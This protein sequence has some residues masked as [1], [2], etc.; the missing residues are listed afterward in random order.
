MDGYTIIVSHSP[1]LMPLIPPVAQS[2]LLRLLT[3][4]LNLALLG[5]TARML[6]AGVRG[7]ISLLIATLG[8]AL[9]IAGMGGGSQLVYLLPQHP[10]AGIYRRA[11]VW[12]IATAGVVTIVALLLQ[13]QLPLPPAFWPA[14]LT[15]FLWGNLNRWML[16]AQG[17]ILTDHRLN[18]VNS[19]LQLTLLAV[20]LYGG[21]SPTLTT[22]GWVLLLSWTI[23]AL[24]SGLLLL[25]LL[26]KNPKPSA[27]IGNASLK[28]QIGGATLIEQPWGA[29]KIEQFGGATLIEQ[30]GGASLKEQLGRTTKPGPLGWGEQLRQG[31]YA[32]G[33]ELIFHLGNRLA[34]YL[35]AATLG[36]SVVGRYALAQALAE[37]FWGMSR[38]VNVWLA[39][40][41]SRAATQDPAAAT[42]RWCRHALWSSSLGSI[43]LILMP[44]HQWVRL[45]G[46]GFRGLSGL[47]P[48]L[49]PGMIALAYQGTLMQY[50]A[51][52]GQFRRNATT[53]GAALLAMALLAPLLLHWMGD[54]G[55]ALAQSLSL[56]FSAALITHRFRRDTRL[57]LRQMLL[58]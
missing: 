19:A 12:T 34:Y 20:L 22:F 45:L 27:V 5:Y 28:E 14:I 24:W 30:P 21:A 15:A 33:T 36:S 9:H 4:L 52:T 43:L 46:D 51:G 8:I 23:M 6:G 26:S 57:S 1:S 42:W 55:V 32:Q 58:A 35:L 17:S 44:D 7:E 13:R 3:A 50:Y 53:A 2:V 41:I 10:G 29:S 56:L 37:A 25:P 40:R 39:G 38:S 11:L 49:A 31:F 54:T 18:V 48:W 16:V 47:I